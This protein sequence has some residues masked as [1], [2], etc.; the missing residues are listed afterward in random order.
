MCGRALRDVLGDKAG[1]SQGKVAMLGDLSQSK[2][3]L[4]THPVLSAGTATVTQGDSTAPQC[5]PKG[6]LT[7]I[8]LEPK[9]GPYIQTHKWVKQGRLGG[10]ID[11]GPQKWHFRLLRKS[12]G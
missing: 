12:K 7:Y 5:G 4:E 9:A 6:K 8:R 10:F 1:H 11:T 2:H 3:G